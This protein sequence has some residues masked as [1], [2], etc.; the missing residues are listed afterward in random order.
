[1][2]YTDAQTR[3]QRLTSQ[4]IQ[5]VDKIFQK[6]KAKG[7]IFLGEDFLLFHFK[8][9]I[10]CEVR[11]FA[12]MMVG[13]HVQR[14]MSLF[15]NSRAESLPLPRLPASFYYHL[16]PGTHLPKAPA[17]GDLPGSVVAFTSK[18]PRVDGSVSCRVNQ[19]EKSVLESEDLYGRSVLPCGCQ[20][21]WCTPGAPW[22]SNSSPQKGRMERGSF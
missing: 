12:L 15:Q 1:M 21:S 6:A 7:K 10:L 20:M 19:Q 2:Y 5:L 16:I 3:R 8:E 9:E 13:E 22:T 18:V 4:W 17:W 11:D 14:M